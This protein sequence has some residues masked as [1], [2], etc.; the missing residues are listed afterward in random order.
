MHTYRTAYQELRK[1]LMNLYDDGEAD[2][3]ADMYF[4]HLTGKTYSQRLV[5]ADDKMNENL[6]EQYTSANEQLSKGVPVQYVMQSAHFMGKDYYV[7][8]HVLIPRPE[9]EELVKLIINENPLPNPDILDIGTG[10]GCIPI[11]LK[12]AIPDATVSTIDISDT[13]IKVAQRN[14]DIHKADINILQGDFPDEYVRAGLAEYDI[15]VSNPPYIPESDKETMHSNVKDHEPEIA[16]FVPDNSPQLFY[17]AIA[18]FGKEHLKD[19]GTI[20]CELHKDHAQGSQQVFLDAGYRTVD[21]IKDMYG[22]PRM[23]RAKKQ[24]V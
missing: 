19:N 22:N 21:I 7:N 3:I 17:K 5:D 16:L 8:E 4:T 13:A 9:T 12:L 15:I 6:L 20:Y 23:L 10:S 18:T 2:A 1:T 11:S 24:G 14:A